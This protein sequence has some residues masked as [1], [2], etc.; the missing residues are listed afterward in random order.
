MRDLSVQKSVMSA[1]EADSFEEVS[2]DQILKSAL[3]DTIAEIVRKALK[4]HRNETSE[5][6][7]VTSSQR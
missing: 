5:S 4:E 6:N 2:Q 3:Q 7:V 1:S